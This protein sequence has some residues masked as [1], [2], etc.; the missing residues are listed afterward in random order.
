MSAAV[1]EYVKHLGVGIIAI[2]GVDANGHC[3]CS[4]GS[5]CGSPGK[6][7]NAK[8][9]PSG[10]KDAVSDPAVLQ[11]WPTGNDC[12]YAIRC[13]DPLPGGGYLGVLD[14][15]PRNGSAE[16]LA[17]IR[18][19]GDEIPATVSASTGG[20]GG[21]LLYRFPHAPASRCVAPGLDLQGAGKY[22]VVA[23]SRHYSGGYYSWDL[24]SAPGEIAVADAPAWLLEGTDEA[25]PRPGRDG[26]DTA[27]ETVLGEAFRLVGWAGS[28]TGRGEL[29]VRCPQWAQHS[30]G[31][32]I[33]L[34]HSTVVLPPA[35]GSRFGG[36]KC[37]HGHCA[38]LK[39]HD[40]KKFLGEEVFKQAE[41]K[42][43]RLSAVP[44]VP[45]VEG[46]PPQAVPIR[47]M[48]I[49]GDQDECRK[50]LAYHQTKN[51]SVPR[52]DIVNMSCILTWDSRWAGLLRYDEF[53]QVLR[54]SRI[55]PWD[56]QD[57]PK[58]QLMV[59][60]DED[61]TRMDLW[62][63][64]K[65][66][67]ELES[68]KIRE[69]IYVVGRRD[70][71]NPL[72]D[73]LEGLVW[74]GQARLDTWLMTYAGVADTP[75]ARGV[76]RKWLLSAVARGYEP[77]CPAH[78]VLV[79]TGAQGKGKS[80]LAS[81][82]VPER[83]WFNDTPIDVGNKDAYLAIRGRWVVEL[84]ELASLRRADVEKIKA[85]FTSPIDNYRPP[86]SREEVAVPRSCVFIGTLN[87]GEYLNDST[88]NRRF[89]TVRTGV[90]DAD[91]MA[92]DR[93]QLWAECVTIY[94]AWC[95]RGRPA[96]ECLWWPTPDE[97]PLFET[98][99]SE[100]EVGNPWAE[101]IALWVAG[102]KAKGILSTRGY[103]TGREIAAGALEIDAKDIGAHVVTSV[104]N[105]MTRDLKWKKERVTVAGAR[106]WGYKP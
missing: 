46:P 76:G 25:K 39:W 74:D 97:V 45:E 66:A 36:F 17:A 102:S 4:K 53:A 61:I 38:N 6:H 2:W 57:S 32:G 58:E 78:H 69:T 67:L 14:F 21:H 30:D 40:V 73:Y 54:F 65:W 99:Q 27:L 50:R 60:T 79:L 10:V 44:K 5:E 70:S 16:S 3:L 64:R 94:K 98:V 100:H 11:F 31:R 83:A 96:S 9:C 23:P 71:I 85:F 105:I 13:G 75:Y 52:P 62:C 34:D 92:R 20:G 56:P 68:G 43:P 28:L 80:T 89:W 35:G 41:A 84:A 33:G 7:P 49:R 37:L 59:W 101:S 82:L 8:I 81:R 48:E 91:A 106:S 51:G 1:L 22:I 86:Y 103:I 29:M 12:N 104:G 93:D 24:G 72:Q 87:M 19:R 26:G 88:G 55:P 42:Y 18:D 63:R 77:G 95:A 47:T 90:I 15:D